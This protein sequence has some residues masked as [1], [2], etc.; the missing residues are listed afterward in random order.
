MSHR[1]RSHKAN[2]TGKSC[3]MI[4]VIA[5][6]GVMSV[7]IVNLYRKDQQYIMQEADLKK[8][9]ESEI[10]RQKELEEYESYTQTQEYIEDTAKSRLGMIYE[11]EIIFKE[12]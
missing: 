12:Q 4:I 9:M 5:L 7:Q 11:D 2:K 8:Q 10:E 6:V 1:Y 3:V